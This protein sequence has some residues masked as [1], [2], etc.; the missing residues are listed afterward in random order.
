MPMWRYLIAAVSPGI[1]QHLALANDLEADQ[2]RGLHGGLPEGSQHGRSHCD[3]TTQTIR[4]EQWYSSLGIDGVG[5]SM[6]R[7]RE[8]PHTSKRNRMTASAG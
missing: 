8:P 2:E 4:R 3:S 6:Q 1:H 7:G 5:G